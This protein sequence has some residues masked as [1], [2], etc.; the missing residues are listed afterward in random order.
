MIAC[1]IMTHGTCG[2]DGQI[3][4]FSDGRYI[5][6]ARFI[7]PILECPELIGR[8]KLFFIQACR[9][10]ANNNQ[11]MMADNPVLDQQSGRRYHSTRDLFIFY[12]SAPGNL[13]WTH[14]DRGSL[15]I[16]HLA[17]GLMA[18]GKTNDLDFIVKKICISLTEEI[19][20]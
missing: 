2:I 4:E 5:S 3:I 16:E 20:F 13:S 11:G 14:R 1:C 8:P 15:F 10:E 6:L 17:N 9:G 18:D 19:E 7:A 12:S